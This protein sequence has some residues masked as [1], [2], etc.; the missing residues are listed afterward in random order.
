[1]PG[2]TAERV[3]FVVKEHA[4]LM[5]RLRR[6]PAAHQML[7]VPRPPDLASGESIIDVVRSQI[8]SA[9]RAVME[10]IDALEPE[11]KRIEHLYIQFLAAGEKTA[12]SDASIKEGS[13]EA[14]L[15][16]VIEARDEIERARPKLRRLREGL[17]RHRR[18]GSPRRKS[19]R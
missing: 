8:P 5:R 14:E 1:M 3:R 18:K 13:R 7:P 12:L 10:A 9:V 2:L 15:S 19:G 16:A 11:R 17:E 4:R 6:M